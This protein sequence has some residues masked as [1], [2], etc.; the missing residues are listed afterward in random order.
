MIL[1]NFL[2][3]TFHVNL[4][5]KPITHWQYTTYEMLLDIADH[6]SNRSRENDLKEKRKEKGI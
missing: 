1:R 6:G 4:S 2:Q 5:K 3:V